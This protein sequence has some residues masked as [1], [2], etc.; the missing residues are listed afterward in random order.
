MSNVT[1]EDVVS[2][3]KDRLDILD[4]V[5]KDVI[6]K[7]S[8]GNYWGLCPFHKEKT[9]SFSVNPAKGI[10][11]CFG[12]GEG[13]DA[14]SYLIK[15]RG[16]TFAELIKELAS[17]F[18][19]EL[20]N[21]FSGVKNKDVREQMI[22]ACYK[23]AEFYQHSLFATADGEQAVSYLS[24]R[25]ID[26]KIIKR[27]MLG[28]ANK[29][30][31]HLYNSLKEQFTDEILEKAG[32]VLK[33]Q[34]GDYIDRFRNRIAIPIHDENGDIVA[35]GARAV[36]E[37]Q[38]PKYLNSSDSL[39]YNKSKILYGLYFAKESIKQSDS[40]IIME[41][42][43]DVISAQANGIENCVASCGTS[44]TPE[45]IKLI[46]RYSKSRKIYL[47]FDT[48]SAGIKATSRGAE[49][50]KEA[51]TGLGN[52][53]QFDEN[54]SNTNNDK[55]ACEIRVITPPEGKDPDEFIRTAGAEAYFKHLE[56]APLLIDFQINEALKQRNEAKTPNEK[57]KL[58]KEII[59]ILAEIQNKI[60]R[61]EYVKMVAS[62][63]NIDEGAMLSEINRFDDVLDELKSDNVKAIVTNSS[64]ILEK[65]QKNLL[66]LF[67]INE[68]HFSYKE[69]NEILS[70]V[71]F[72]NEKLIIVKNTIDKLICSVNN[73]KALTEQLY[74]NFAQDEE[75]KAII[76]DLI[77]ISETFNKLSKKDFMLVIDENINKINN[78]LLDFEKTEMRKIYQD[79]N[80]DDNEALK[81]QMQLRDKINSIVIG[82]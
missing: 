64:N 51:F 81:I 68:S 28:F 59:P 8:G 63:L 35:F 12:C 26:E 6:L 32:L 20:P 56:H 43:F 52:I 58:V 55:Y 11:K 15:T 79:V 30:P 75:L 53:K 77:C 23:A 71:Q 46:S 22:K 41:G 66:S 7:K 1:F 2:Q 38:N 31:S 49:I 37:G 50:I 60:I 5:S 40:I 13:G 65:A 42:Y 82:D 45:H 62:T 57:M 4:V 36:E 54:Y 18:G 44:L 17:E 19:L 70:K 61:T 14:L 69:L 16:I 29:E 80:N 67:L 72:S 73:V 9:P 34:K 25:G 33:T 76:T 10:F 24:N 47:A 3:I 48:D 21:T 39:I 27:Y 74:V 78:C